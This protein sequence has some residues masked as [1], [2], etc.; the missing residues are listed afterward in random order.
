MTF[1]GQTGLAAEIVPREQITRDLQPLQHRLVAA[2]TTDW[3]R[4]SLLGDAPARARLLA[5]Q[6]LQKGDLWQQ[7]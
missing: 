1:G 7:K 4:A 5:P 2:I 6:G 3:W